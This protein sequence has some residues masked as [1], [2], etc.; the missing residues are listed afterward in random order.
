MSSST[1]GPSVTTATRPDPARVMLKSPA[2]RAPRRSSLHPLDV[3]VDVRIEG[4]HVTA[5]ARDPIVGQPEQVHILRLVSEK[6]FT[7]S[8]DLHQPGSLTP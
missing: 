6:H 2:A 7:G 5:V 3:P 4:E 8:T 1:G